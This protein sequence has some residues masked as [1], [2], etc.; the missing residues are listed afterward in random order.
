MINFLCNINNN[1]NNKIIKCIILEF[2]LNLENI[3]EI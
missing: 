3:N 2:Y 1:N